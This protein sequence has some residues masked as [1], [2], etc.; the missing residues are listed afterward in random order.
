MAGDHPAEDIFSLS[1]KT[2]LV[3]GGA[4][5]LG[6]PVCDALAARGARLAV[7]DRDA[8]RL[9]ETVA[10]LN[11]RFPGS[12]ARG[13]PVDIAAPGAPEALIREA[14]ENGPA[15]DILVNA[16][17]ASA[18]QPLEELTATAMERALKLNLVASFLLAR[19]AAAGMK[20][21][22]S[23][24]FFS[25]MYGRVSP[26]PRAYEPPMRP[27]PIEY[28]VAKAGLDQMVRY[29]AVHYAPRNIRVNAVCPGP[30]PNAGRS[31]Y[32][33]DP[34]FEAFVER[35]ACRVPLG[36]V[37]RRGEMAGP[38]VFLASPAASFITG[39]VLVVDGGWTAW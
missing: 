6:G 25:S 32:K 28:G 39:Q 5:Y 20:A 13:L 16:T 31:E 29:L 3:V 18:G 2:A 33:R 11:E 38:V 19:T 37:G 22:G 7:A 14:A 8:G 35:L 21:G 1:G 27:N 12:R 36:R 15:P 26:D 9:E 24:I 4:G 10:R 34:G 23:I 30:F 17:A